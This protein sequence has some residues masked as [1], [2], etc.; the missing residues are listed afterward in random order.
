[1]ILGIPD[2]RPLMLGVKLILGKLGIRPNSKKNTIGRNLYRMYKF[3]LKML[4]DSRV[5]L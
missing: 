2:I 3:V 1:M 5:E 4:H